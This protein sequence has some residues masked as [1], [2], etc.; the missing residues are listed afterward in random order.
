[1]LLV[2]HSLYKKSH[3]GIFKAWQWLFVVLLLDNLLEIHKVFGERS[4]SAEQLGI[5]PLEEFVE[6]I[7][8]NLLLI[9]CIF[10]IECR[11][12]IENKKT[13]YS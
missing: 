5:D 9:V 1:M 8:L 13:V 4:I 3:A 10:S 2:L 6:I 11:L 12:H 7:G